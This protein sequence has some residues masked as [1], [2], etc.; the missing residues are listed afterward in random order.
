[1][2][3]KIGSGASTQRPAG[4]SFGVK[5]APK[6]KEKVQPTK[7]SSIF[8]ESLDHD[9]RMGHEFSKAKLPDLMK[10][11]SKLVERQAAKLLQEDPTVFSYDEVYEEECSAPLSQNLHTDALEQK[12]RVGLVLRSAP[13]KGQSRYLTKI[14]AATD[15]RKVEQQIIEDK[16]LKKKREEEGN[17]FG[18]KEEFLTA[19][20]KEEL[21]KRNQFE[22]DMKN[23]DQV[24]E[25]ND[26][27]R[28]QQGLGFADFN[29][30]LLN[31]GLA[32]TGARRDI[33][34]KK[35]ESTF[36]APGGYK[37]REGLLDGATCGH[38]K[39]LSG[40]NVPL[41]VTVKSE[42]TG[43]FD[44]KAEVKEEPDATAEQGDSGMAVS[45]KMKVEKE[46]KEV[47]MEV[48]QEPAEEEMEVE[49]DKGKKALTAA[50]VLAA[51]SERYAD[52]YEVGSGR[53]QAHFLR[54]QVE[55]KIKDQ[56]FQSMAKK[57][58]T[59]HEQGSTEKPEMGPAT[60]PLSAA[61]KAVQRESK[62][63]SA[64]ERYLARKKAEKE[65][66]K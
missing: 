52:V 30:N 65:P 5:P 61:E 12:K 64:K 20:Y 59:T 27:M 43:V 66:A 16:L 8:Q 39:L 15:N 51:A 31:S 44:V 14:I 48:K 28:K 50:E 18:D 25:A 58:K 38:H 56:E 63:S 22:E 3:F 60:A 53:S 54:K 49:E 2:N 23:K 47:K 11:H 6:P 37:I 34:E 40:G 4:L 13:E 19:A 9:E 1:M 35:L 36:A 24:D 32:R 57:L 55:Q 46:D 45:S 42:E 26:A 7:A 62:A 17:M 21:K 10:T 29:R 33:A 41:G